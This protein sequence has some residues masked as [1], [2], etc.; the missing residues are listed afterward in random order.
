MDLT[1]GIADLKAIRCPPHHYLGGYR[2]GAAGQLLMHFGCIDTRRE[3]GGGGHLGCGRR[4]S[5]TGWFRW[6]EARPLEPPSWFIFCAP[7][8]FS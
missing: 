4:A 1:Y 6:I 7:C 5:Q 8:A 3:G 2:L